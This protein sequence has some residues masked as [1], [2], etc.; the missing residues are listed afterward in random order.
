VA[1]GRPLLDGDAELVAVWTHPSARGTGLGTAVVRAVVAWAEPCPRLWACVAAGNPT[2]ERL[3]TRLGFRRSGITE[4]NPHDPG[5][6][7]HRL[8]L[9][10]P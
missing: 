4:P 7:D 2:A 9:T 10:K 5:L 6:D 1:V 8:V 3:Y